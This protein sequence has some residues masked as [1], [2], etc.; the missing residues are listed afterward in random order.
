M[1]KWDIRPARKSDAAALVGCI[2]AAYAQYV[3]RVD[4]LPAVSDGIAEDIENHRVWVAEQAG[5]VV[6]GLILIPHETFA[7][8]VNVAVD[9]SH[10]GLGLGRGLMA[11]AEQECRALGLGELRLSTHVAMPENVRLYEHLGWQESDRSGNKVHMT[12]VL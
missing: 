12:K 10:N 3:G 11:R 7:V 4:D 9:P 8:L 6:G 1:Q 5:S 2:D